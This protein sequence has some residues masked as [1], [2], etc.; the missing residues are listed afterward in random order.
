MNLTEIQ[1]R[2]LEI[3][4]KYEQF[5]TNKYGKPW[6]IEDLTIGLVGDIGD[7]VKLVQAQNGK[8][9]IEDSQEKL[10]HELSDCLWSILII[11]KKYNIDLEKAFMETM[12]S[13]DKEISDK[14]IKYLPSLSPT[15]KLQAGK[16]FHK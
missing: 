15:F 9:E 2:A 10:A 1:N 13:L 6:S 3:R 16:V 7:L 12:D 11:A 5:E 14:L 4:E 8:R